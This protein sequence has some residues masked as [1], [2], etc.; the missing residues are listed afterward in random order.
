MI[1]S[2]NEKEQPRGSYCMRF[3]PAGLPIILM[4]ALSLAECAPTPPP[5]A[6]SV[7][8]PEPQ[9]PKP[10]RQPPST[11]EPVVA[12]W[13]FQEDGES[14]KAA[15][16]NPALTLEI[17]VSDDRLELL[18][19]AK[20]RPA[21]RRGAHAAIAFSGGSGAWTASGRLTAAHV[22]SASQPMG[23]AAVGRVLVLLSGGTVQVGG[24]HS[25]LP[26]LRVPDAGA[27]GR[28]WFACVRRRL[29][30]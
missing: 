9:K 2:Q 3:A 24:P 13:K 7:A 21:L 11:P 23:E 25:R 6:E 4:I 27:A 29:F 19:Q 17:A 18:A 8:I 5:V 30:P 1:P 15:A 16:T 12:T 20:M 22:I 14:C 26:S 10:P 28:T